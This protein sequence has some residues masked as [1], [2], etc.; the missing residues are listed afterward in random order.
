MKCL[1][2]TMETRIVLEVLGTTSTISSHM[3]SLVVKC[4][5]PPVANMP[6]GILTACCLPVC[7]TVSVPWRWRGGGLWQHRQRRSS[8][9]AIPLHRSHCYYE[10]GKAE[11][12][13][14]NQTIWEWESCKNLVGSESLGGG[15]FE[16]DLE[17][18]RLLHS[19]KSPK[20]LNWP[21]SRLE[22]VWGT[23]GLS[24][25]GFEKGFEV[26]FF[27]TGNTMGENW[28]EPVW[29]WKKGGIFQTHDDPFPFW[30]SLSKK[31][32]PELLLLKKGWALMLET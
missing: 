30:K 19:F 31:V 20:F 12:A 24:Q 1:I 9:P 29:I 28:A 13:G 10:T 18:F 23:N 11:S 7:V 32:L 4:W 21:F 17:D 27:K 6:A 16:I 25:S 3:H 26:V 14:W 15:V 22:K 8:I 5:E 2:D